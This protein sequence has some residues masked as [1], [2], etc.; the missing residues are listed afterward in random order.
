MRALLCLSGLILLASLPAEAK[1]TVINDSGTLPYAPTLALHWQQLSPRPPLNNLLTGT[2]TL[3]VKLNVAAWLRRSGRI[4]LRLP[5]QQPG[6]MTA[7]WTTQGR[8]LPGEITT[9]NRMLVYAGQITTPFIEDVLQLT[10]NVDAAR[11]QQFY[12][13]NFIFEMDED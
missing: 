5:A 1:T 6:A 3:R 4:Y 11:I 9:G 12:R 8:L 13:V 10:L 7:S 2:L